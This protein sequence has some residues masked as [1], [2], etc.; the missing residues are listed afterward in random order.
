MDT[1]SQSE[2]LLV[3]CGEAVA[4]NDLPLANVLIAQLHQVVSIYGNPMQRLAAYMMEGLIARQST[5][6]QGSTNCRFTLSYA[7]HV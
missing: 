4:N 6:V 1:R 5:E 3:A 2:Q 7:N